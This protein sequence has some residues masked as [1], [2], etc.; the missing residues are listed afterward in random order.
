MITTVGKLLKS[1]RI[2]NGWSSFDVSAATG[3]SRSRIEWIEND[4]RKMIDVATAETL[5]RHYRVDLRVLAAIA[6]GED[7]GG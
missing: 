3:I 7:V 2:S 5:C 6:L 1:A 4:R